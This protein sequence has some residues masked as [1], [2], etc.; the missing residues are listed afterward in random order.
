MRPICTIGVS[1][2]SA[3]TKSVR[4]MMRQIR[5]AGAAAAFLSSQVKS[6]TAAVARD[7]G[8][9]NALVLMGNSLD[10]DPKRYAHRYP[11]DSHKRKC[12]PHTRSEMAIP[13]GAAR[14]RY[15]EAILQAALAAKMP[16]LGVCGGMQ[17]INVSL[18]GTL[19]Q[20][21]PDMVGSDRHMQARRG[22]ALHIPVVPIVIKEDTALA[23]IARGIR[24]PFVRGSGCPT[25][26]MENSLHHQALDIIAPGLCV[27]AVTDTVRLP[28]G[29]MGYLAEAIESDPDGDY[30]GQCI[31]GVQWHPEFG[32][33]SLGE[34]IVRHIVA[35]ARQFSR[36]RKNRIAFT[37][38]HSIKFF[39]PP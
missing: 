21:I 5:E 8:R 30:A 38:V 16:L 15:E 26:L 29:T 9:I 20:H 13:K 19:H 1:G 11:E 6:L 22:I 37:C 7:L 14:A 3:H 23:Q 27:S 28:D 35:S 31:M 18:G 39:L 17:R 24:M 2:A 10:I 34:R 25:V 32:A 36:A 4:A 33:S 12:H